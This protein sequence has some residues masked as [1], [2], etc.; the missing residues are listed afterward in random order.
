MAMTAAEYK[1]DLLRKL[2]GDAFIAEKEA[3]FLVRELVN[4]ETDA[5]AERMEDKIDE[6]TILGGY[7]RTLAAQIEEIDVV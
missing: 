7:L 4:A 1:E 2:S 5:I 6:A 3:V